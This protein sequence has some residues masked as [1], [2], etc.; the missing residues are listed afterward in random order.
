MNEIS[1][2][3]IDETQVLQ[4]TI[5]NLINARNQQQQ[6][7]QATYMDEQSTS[8]LPNR[9]N[10]SQEILKVIVALS[11][12]KL[13]IHSLYKED[14]AT[15]TDD[16][17]GTSLNSTYHGLA[18]KCVSISQMAASI[19]SSNKNTNNNNSNHTA[20]YMN[21]VQDSNAC[22]FIRVVTRK[23]GILIHLG[24]LISIAEDQRSFIMRNVIS[25]DPLR[26][27]ER[28]ISTL[29]PAEILALTESK[30]Q[31]QHRKRGN[32]LSEYLQNQMNFGNSGNSLCENTSQVNLS[33]REHHHQVHGPLL[34]TPSDVLIHFSEVHELSIIPVIRFDRPKHMRQNSS[35]GKF[36]Q[37]TQFE[38]CEH[39]YHDVSNTSKLTDGTNK[40]SDLSV[41]CNESMN[42]ANGSTNS[43]PCEVTSQSAETT[44]NDNLLILKETDQEGGKKSSLKKTNEQMQDEVGAR[45]K[46]NTSVKHLKFSENKSISQMECNAGRNCDSNQNVQPD[47]PI[48]VSDEQKQKVEIKPQSV[49]KIKK[50]NTSMESRR[51]PERRFFNKQRYSAAD[52]NVKTQTKSL[53]FSGTSFLKCPT[54]TPHLTNNRA[55][56]PTKWYDDAIVSI[57]I[58]QS[59]LINSPANCSNSLLKTRK[60]L[61]Q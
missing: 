35:N 44:N 14:K 29:K 19:F 2:T 60:K 39:S 12:L 20:T 40:E 61:A 56:S 41:T 52:S 34:I 4:E 15:Q 24:Q 22:P 9:I 57:T 17:P 33:N 27:H 10:L 6:Q 26:V 47:Q 1:T 55:G 5:H 18:S 31:S 21:D 16:L 49:R 32:L 45:E 54:S 59:S 43:G 42:I 38:H 30:L 11:A 36:K 3:F 58:Q 37:L 7:Q 28:T 53:N 50:H 13:P 25:F 8:C 23:N 46:L 51:W 48:E